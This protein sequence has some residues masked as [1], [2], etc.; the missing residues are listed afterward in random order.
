MQDKLDII[1]NWMFLDRAKME[2]FLFHLKLGR[3]GK[4]LGALN[5][6]PGHNNCFYFP[7]YVQSD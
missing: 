3:K 5:S 4:G 1:L 2:I 6:L 7:V